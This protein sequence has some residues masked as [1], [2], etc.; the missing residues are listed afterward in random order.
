MCGKPLI[1]AEVG[2]G[3]SHINIDQQTGLVVTPGCPQ[4]LR[5]AMDRLF[6]HP[7]EAERMGR[8]ARRRYEEL[9]TGASMGR[10]YAEVYRSVL[11][12]RDTR[13]NLALGQPK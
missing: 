7:R 3:T 9:F 12:E 13:S 10:Q 6:Y 8:E 5:A 2:S 4:S 1:S 11:A